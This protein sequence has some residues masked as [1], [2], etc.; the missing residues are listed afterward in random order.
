M[1]M[2]WVLVLLNCSL[3]LLTLMEVQPRIYSEHRTVFFPGFR[4]VDNAV[5]ISAYFSKDYPIEAPIHLLENVLMTMF[6]S[7]HFQLDPAS[8]MSNREWRSIYSGPYT[9]HLGSEHRIFL[10]A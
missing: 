6:E 10:I 3:L 7:T 4:D 1:G 2:L 5:K 9:L 8:S